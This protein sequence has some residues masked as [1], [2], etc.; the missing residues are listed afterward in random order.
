MESARRGGRKAASIT[1]LVA[2]AVRK[3]YGETPSRKSPKINLTP[4]RATVKAP[5]RSRLV[6]SAD[7]RAALEPI[8]HFFPNMIVTQRTRRPQPELTER[9]PSNLS[10]SVNSVRNSGS[11]L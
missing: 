6:T 5:V 2:D 1:K 7:I 3:T 4:G 10:G 11:A 9:D 8:L